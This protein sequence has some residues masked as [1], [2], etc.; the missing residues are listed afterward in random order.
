[1]IALISVLEH[2]AGQAVG[3]DVKIDSK[4]L[5]S[6]NFLN[7]KYWKSSLS[8]TKQRLRLAYCRAIQVCSSSLIHVPGH[9]GIWQDELA[10]RTAKA[11]LT[12]L[13]IINLNWEIIATSSFSRTFIGQPPTFATTVPLPRRIS[14]QTRSTLVRASA[15]LALFISKM[16]L[17]CGYTMWNSD[18]RPIE[19]PL[20]TLRKHAETPESVCK[21]SFL[22]I[23]RIS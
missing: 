12:D 20:Q 9:S 8:N 22:L 3:R 6:L 23:R 17:D 1:M 13:G 14:P 15:A 10:D 21:P 2:A 19:L 5:S 16:I 11:A 7:A 18:E 4:S